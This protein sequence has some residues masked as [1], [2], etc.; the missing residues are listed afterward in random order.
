M[1]EA[2]RVD[3][4]RRLNEVLAALRKLTEAYAEQGGELDPLVKEA[5]RVLDRAQ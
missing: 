1:A 5:R 2:D 4:T 3:L